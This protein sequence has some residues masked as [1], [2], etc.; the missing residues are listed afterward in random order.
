M[1]IS[2]QSLCFKSRRWCGIDFIHTQL[3]SSYANATRQM[4]SSPNKVGFITRDFHPLIF[5]QR[6][7]TMCCGLYT[8]FLTSKPLCMQII[9]FVDVLLATQ[10]VLSRSGRF[11]CGHIGWSQLQLA[12]SVSSVWSF[13]FYVTTVTWYKSAKYTNMR[14]TFVSWRKHNW[15]CW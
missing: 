11:G 14:T 15:C 10:I 8:L 3:A 4:A 9:S 5:R 13:A 6:S 12:S 1:T 7:K 2:S